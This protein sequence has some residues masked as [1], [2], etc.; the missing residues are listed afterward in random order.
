VKTSAL[1]DNSILSHGKFGR[2]ISIALPRF[3]NRLA[4]IEAKPA[5]PSDQK[6]L[7][8]QIEALPTIAKAVREAKLELYSYFELEMEEWRG[9]NFPN[10][11]AGNVFHDVL[12]ERVAAPIGR[13]LFVGICGV[14]LADVDAQISFCVWLLKN[15]EEILERPKLLDRLTPTQI[16]ALRDIGRFREICR[17]LAPK[18]YVDAMHLWTGEINGIENFLTMDATLVRT[19]SSNKQLTL[20]CQPVYPEDLL[21]RMGLAE[22]EPLPLEYGRRYLLSGVPYD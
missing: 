11:V 3:G 17:S 1:I 6:W 5:L 12:I 15:G 14:E 18:Q 4:L 9:G 13:S 10:S 19:L 22:R 21:T 8:T 2:P 20:L 16:N 7:R